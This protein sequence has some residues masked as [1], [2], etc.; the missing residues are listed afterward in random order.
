MTVVTN[1]VVALQIVTTSLV[2]CPCPDN[3]PGCLVNHKRESRT[4]R[5]EIPKVDSECMNA[6]GSQSLK[7]LAMDGFDYSTWDVNI[8]NIQHELDWTG[9]SKCLH[10]PVRAFKYCPGCDS[11]IFSDR[12]IG[13]LNVHDVNIALREINSRNKHKENCIQQRSK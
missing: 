10:I 4:V 3:D 1:L 12:I 5:Y 7:C 13:L 9:C 6:D 11:K 8:V 2:D